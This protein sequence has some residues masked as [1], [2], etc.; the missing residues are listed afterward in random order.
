M[1]TYT[2]LKVKQIKLTDRHYPIG[3]LSKRFKLN[4]T[5]AMQSS[6]NGFAS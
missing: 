2:V 5:G 4:S 6:S 1:G 3:E